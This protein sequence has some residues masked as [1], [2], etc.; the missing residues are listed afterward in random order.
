MELIRT[1]TRAEGGI[2][3]EE[4]EKMD[5]LTKKWIKNALQT[6]ETDKEKLIGAIKRLYKVSGLKEPRVV[7]VP[8]PKVMALAYGIAAGIWYLRKNKKLMPK[9][10][11]AT[12]EATREAT[13]KATRVAT[14]VA[15]R[16]ATFAATFA[17][18]FY[19]TEEATEEAIEEATRVATEEA[20]RDA[21]E[22]ATLAA[23]RD[24]TEEAT[25]AATREATFDAT[26]ETTR[27]ATFDATFAATEEATRAAFKKINN[28]NWLVSLAQYFA[29]KNYKFVISCIQYWYRAYQG[30]NMW[31]GFIAYGDACE[32][33]LR[34]T[35]LSVWEAFHAYRDSGIYGGFRAMHEKFCIVSDF[36]EYIKTNKDN[37]PHCETGPSHRWRDGFEIYYLN[38]I[39]MTKKQVMTPAE[40]LDI[41]EILN[42]DNVDQQRE[43]IRKV[44]AER[45]ILKSGMKPI[46]SFVHI[47][48]N[49]KKL[50][51]KL[52]H[53]KVK[54]KDRKYLY[55]EH[56]T[57]PGVFYARPVPPECTKAIH[58]RAWIAHAIERAEIENCDIKQLQECLP[59]YVD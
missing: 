12:E 47:T 49:N 22:E 27:E 10:Y 15:T 6:G 14:R 38:G 7:I 3:P 16:E 17:A 45:L 58:G 9:I 55:Y 36:P 52:Y 53:L 48:K 23:T 25:L 50:E 34:L 59:D 46:D 4:K 44:G 57:L 51:Y 43:L 26:E 19:A 42:M 5:K 33:V 20:T 1:P 24:A 40:E 8:S 56:A 28:K 32:N 29:G 30:G 11:K 31:S 2:T 41:T 21:T 18:T 13:E 37:K 54:D 39:K 35:G